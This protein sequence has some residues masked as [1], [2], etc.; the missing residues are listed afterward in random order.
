M[1]NIL[2]LC[3]NAKPSGPIE[4]FDD[5]LHINQ[6]PP[7]RNLRLEVWNISHWLLRKLDSVNRDLLDI[8]AFIYYADNS[9]RRG[10]EKDLFQENWVRRFT[11]VIPVRELEIWQR[12]TVTSNLIDLLEYLTEDKFTFIFTQREEVP[13]QLS[14]KTISD[15]LPPSP[16]ADG[17][18]LFSGG[19]DSL[20]GAVYLN[21]NE[22]RP[23]LVSHQTRPSLVKLQ[24]TLTPFLRKL[25][26][27]WS[28]PHL[29]VKINRVG[30]NN[31]R[32][33]SQRSRSFLFLTLGSLVANELEFN[34]L[35]VFEN[36]ITSFNFPRLA[37]VLGSQATRSTHPRV[38]MLF[39]DLASELFGKQFSIETPF[40]WKTRR[41]IIDLLIQHGC[42]DLIP[43]ASSC[44]QSR[45]TIIHPHCGTCSQCV[46]R[47]FAVASAGLN[48][49][50]ELDGYEVNIFTD[51]LDEGDAK[52]QAVSAVNFAHD[53]RRRD[54]DSFCI[55]FGEVYD[56]IDSL[57]GDSEQNIQ[58][59]YDLHQRYA[60][61]VSNVMGVE[62][63]KNWE[64]AYANELPDQCLVMLAGPSAHRRPDTLISR[65]AEELIHR[66]IETPVGKAKPLEDIIEEI[67]IFLFCEDLPPARALS[68]P[69]AQSKTDQGYHERDL[70]FQ[71]RASEGFWMNAGRE[72]DASGI[73]VDAKNY[74]KEINGDTVVGFSGKYLK[75]HGLGR[76]GIIAARKV[77]Q[78][79]KEA[80]SQNTRTHGAIEAQK[81]EWRTQEKM[82]ILLGEDDIVEMLEMKSRREFPTELLLDRIFTLKSRQ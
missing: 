44:A 4:G 45:R 71:N 27:K 29:G 26:A 81:N 73:I 37:Q 46:D 20:A 54:I 39:Q 6:N 1:G 53:L 52:M 68:E 70:I 17:V 25:P 9:V 2:A 77:P 62:I 19:L 47:R 79:T 36:G 67:F 32:E 49:P 57:P 42:E 63:G 34:K 40:I 64:N 80:V 48:M 16:N 75:K 5:V 33:S 14:F 56:A 50:D 13:E 7:G 3:D 35:E 59:I 24:R 22:R 65:R 74:T 51:A 30:G 11:F 38:I 66:L 43:L 10:T 72:Y 12:E 78:E 18:A 55:K 61:D 23:V 60:E 31:A 82:V 58:A 28:F 8:A 21:A 41:E 76:L 15:A 69:I